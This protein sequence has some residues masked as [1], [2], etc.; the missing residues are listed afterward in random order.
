[1]DRVMGVDA[2]RT[3]W[4]GIVLEDL[5]VH[6][7]FGASITALAERAGT[8]DI[9]AVDMPIGLPDDST[10]QADQLAKKQ[11]GSSVFLTPTR[12]ALAEVDHAA[13]S[14]VNRRVAGSGISI[15]AYSLRPKVVEVDAWVRTTAPGEVVEAHP[16]LSFRH[17]AGER[18]VTGKK[19]WAGAA[20]RRALL[21]GAG[22]VLPDDLGEAGKHAGVDDVLDAAVLAWTARRVRLGEAVS[23][24]DPPETFSDG[25]PAAIWA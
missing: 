11:V 13:A 18:L 19:T 1:M 12:A 6:A 8:A 22:I 10:R 3:G 9:T 21:A 23:Y 2:C 14:A 7:V 4:V 15:Q 20:A 25:L 5:E 17:L 16:E 24:P